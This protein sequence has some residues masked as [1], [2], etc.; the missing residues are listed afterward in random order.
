MYR[1][2]EVEWRGLLSFKPLDM[3]A[4]GVVAIVMAGVPFAEVPDNLSLPQRWKIDLGDPPAPPGCSSPGDVEVA[5]GIEL[6]AQLFTA[7]GRIGIE[8]LEQLL[9]YDP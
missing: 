5:T 2:P 1:S 3:W 7:M 6:L 9:T 8:L 4:L